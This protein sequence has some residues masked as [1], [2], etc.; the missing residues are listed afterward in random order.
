MKKQNCFAQVS[1]AL[2]CLLT[3]GL[4]EVSSII[5][6][7]F[8]NYLETYVAENYLIIPCALFVGAALTLKQPRDARR[9]RAVGMVCVLWFVLIQLLHQTTEQATRNVG[10]FACAMLLAYPYPA[11]AGDNQRRGLRLVGWLYTGVAVLLCLGGLL[12]KMEMLPGW[13][14]EAFCWDGTRL[15]AARHPN[16]TACLL[17]I[18]IAFCLSQVKRLR[19]WWSKSALVLLTVVFYYF[20]AITNG[21]TAIMV[22]SGMISGIFLLNF[23]RKDWKR[24]VLLLAAAVILTVGLYVGATKLY[25]RHEQAL[26]A[27]F[28]AHQVMT[29][30]EPA[31][32]ADTAPAQE[33]GLPAAPAKETP[34]SSGDR[35]LKNQML[36]LNGRLPTWKAAVKALRDNPS[37]LICGKHYVKEMLSYY[38]GSRID[39]A[40]NSFLEVTLWLGLPGLAMALYFS[41]LAVRGSLRILFDNADLEGKCAALL[42]LGLLVCAILEPILFTG[43]DDYHF[44]NFVF[45]LCVGYLE[46]WRRQLRSNL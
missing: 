11:V 27:Q 15:N 12:L 29:Q 36:H 38:R 16:I 4:I 25:Y 39:H 21:R 35:S 43:A 31:A 33:S 26:V 6:L 42:T 24:I 34:P 3:A 10:F 13:L 14:E 22:T 46:V 28:Y 40:H 45:F 2:F 5:R 23:Y 20:Q 37:V 18:A 17:M 44:V 8:W 7:S 30:P 1:V 41:F 19:R 32:P 9:A